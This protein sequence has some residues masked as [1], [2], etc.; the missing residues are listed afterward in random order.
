MT[1]VLVKETIRAGARKPEPFLIPS[2]CLGIGTC[3]GVTAKPDAAGARMPAGSQKRLEATRRVAE[4]ARA[5][6]VQGGCR[7]LEWAGAART[8]RGN[9]FIIESELTQDR[10]R[11]NSRCARWTGAVKWSSVEPRGGRVLRD[12]THIHERPAGNIVGV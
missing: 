6:L 12:P 4:P 3:P 2:R 11:V 10:D 1:G 5:R 7:L 8:Q 9:P